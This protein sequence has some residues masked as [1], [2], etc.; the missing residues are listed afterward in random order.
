MPTREIYWNITGHSWMYLF[1]VLSL[2]SFA[3]GAWRRCRLWQ[4]GRAE[5][6]FDRPLERLKTVLLHGPGH[7]RLLR[8]AYPGVMHLFICWGFFFLFMGTVVVFLQSDLGLKVMYGRFYLWFQSLLL[9]LVGFLAVAGIMMA[10]FRRYLLRPSRL[11][12]TRDDAVSLLLILAILV[13]GFLLEGLRI[14]GTA[15]PWARWSPVGY[16][17]AAAFQGLDDAA[18]SG[19]HRWL[20]WGHMLL[21]FA[22]IGYLPYSKLFHIFLSPLNQYQ[23]SLAP[24]GSLS[25]LDLEDE[26]IE[27]YGVSRLEEFTSKQLLDGDACTRCGRCQDRCPAHLSGK[28]LSPKALTQSLRAHLSEKGPVLL[29]RAAGAA[30]VARRGGTSAGGGGPAAGAQAGVAAASP[31]EAAIREKPLVGE[32]VAEEA[33]WACTTCRAC[34]EHCPVFVEPVQKIVDLRRHLVLMESRFPPEV[35]AVFRHL[36]TNGNPWGRGKASRGDWAV[37]LGVKTLPE[38][39]EYDWLYWPGCAGA[40]DDRNRRVTAAVVRVLEAAGVKVTALGAKERCC[41]D[42]ARRLGNEYLYQALARENIETLRDYG[43]S[44]IVTPCPHCFNTL[45]HEYPQFG[46]RF[47]VVHHSQL[48]AGLLAEGRLQPARH[49]D[50]SIVYHDSCYLGRYNGV[51]DQPRAVLRALPGSRLLEPRRSRE[52]SFCCGAGGGRMW[53]EERLGR[54]INEMRTEELLTPG[55][56]AIAT[57]CPFCLTMLEDGLK[58]REAREEVPAL[59]VAEV[60]ALCLEEEVPR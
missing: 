60:L 29:A 34:E 12:N 56:G 45:K 38:G 32:V 57:A 19:L 2:A 40:F 31:K 8:E 17:V 11:D 18:I 6:R 42:S 43:V 7:L 21:A 55:P 39:L 49:L 53:M 9:D 27:S 15:D 37:E 30:G 20:W 50:R 24:A 54:R 10:L 3:Y 48:L 33:V 58:A 59:D 25:T 36:E 35:Q 22:F 26:G 47:E 28:P 1:L 14:V 51:Y 23:R 52:E 44:K 41:G 13:T 16:A 46:G 5:H 4:A